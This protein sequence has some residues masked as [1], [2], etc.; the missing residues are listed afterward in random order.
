L[1]RDLEGARPT[2]DVEGLTGRVS[3]LESRTSTLTS[4]I[5]R[6]SSDVQSLKATVAT[7][8]RDVR[9]LKDT[10]LPSPDLAGRVQTNF[11]LGVTAV[12][13]SVAA[14]GVAIFFSG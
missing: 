11:I 10:G 14:L 2:G 7:L 13:L 12:V 1:I 4:D 3:T 8:E 5:S 9:N 6:L